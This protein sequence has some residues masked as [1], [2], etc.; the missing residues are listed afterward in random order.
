MKTGINGEPFITCTSEEAEFVETVFGDCI[1]DDCAMWAIFIE[2]FPVVRGRTPEDTERILKERKNLFE[3]HGMC[4]L[5]QGLIQN[6]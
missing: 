1:R 5:R 4:G 2:Y 3:E 6:A